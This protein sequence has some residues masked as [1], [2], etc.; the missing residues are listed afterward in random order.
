MGSLW[1]PSFGAPEA[2][3]K[4]DGVTGQQAAPMARGH[5]FPLEIVPRDLLEYGRQVD[6]GEGEGIRIGESISVVI[7]EDRHSCLSLVDWQECLSS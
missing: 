5:D 2:S 4:V 7:Q 3:R 6:S 1:A